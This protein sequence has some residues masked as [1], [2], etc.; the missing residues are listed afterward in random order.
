VFLLKFLL[1]DFTV[2]DRTL[3]ILRHPVQ[4]AEYQPA[5]TL[6]TQYPDLLVAV[7]ALRLV[8]LNKISQYLLDF[9]DDCRRL[10]FRQQH[11]RLLFFV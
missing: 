3:M 4:V 7:V 9:L 2:I 8:C 6:H 11:Y 5:F 1:T 10:N